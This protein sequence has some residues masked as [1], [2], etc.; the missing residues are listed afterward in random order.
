[1]RSTPFEWTPER[2]EVLE[3]LYRVAG[4][5]SDTVGSVLGCSAKSVVRKAGELSWGAERRAARRAARVKPFYGK[6]RAA[7][8]GAISRPDAELI[9]EAVA[10]GRV[11]VVEPGIAA[12]LSAWE[13][14]TGYA[15]PPPGVEFNGPR[16]GAPKK[17]DL[18]ARQAA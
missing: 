3:K 9:A 6:E 14:A 1:M 8:A 18:A 17:A 15:V 16:F 7:R 2:L 13:R 10:A 4:Q 12:G 5:R 11:R